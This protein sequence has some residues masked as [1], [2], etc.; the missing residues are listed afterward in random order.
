MKQ[1]KKKQ[2]GNEI[3]EDYIYFYSEV[4]KDKRAKDGVSIVIKKKISK[5][6]QMLTCY[7]R[8]NNYNAGTT[9]S[10]GRNIRFKR[11]LYQPEEIGIF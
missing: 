5:E 8:K 10:N 2:E 4:R 7:K 11:R 6:Y 1:R 9:L 3:K